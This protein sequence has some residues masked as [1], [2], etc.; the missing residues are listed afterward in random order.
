MRAS[1]ILEASDNWKQAI[2]GSKRQLGGSEKWE[3]AIVG[4]KREKGASEH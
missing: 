4:R 1:D 2:A 3:Q